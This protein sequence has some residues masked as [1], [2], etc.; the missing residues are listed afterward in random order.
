M[1]LAAERKKVGR[2][3]FQVV[4]L[5][6]D[7]CRLTY[8][9][10][11]CAA[12]IGTTGDDR[13]YNTRATCQDPNNYDRLAGK[14]FDTTADRLD[15]AAALSGVA[16]SKSGTL[17]ALV[18][19]DSDGTARNI[20]GSTSNK[21]EAQYNSSNKF[22]VKAENAAGTEILNLLSQNAILAASG[23][24][25]FMVSW[26][27]AVAGSARMF[28][29][30]QNILA[31]TGL[32]TTD[33]TIDYAGATSWT[34]GAFDSGSQP[35]DGGC[36][37]LYFAPGQ[38]T[39]W[40][41]PYLR[42]RVLSRFGNLVNLGT[43]G[44]N[45]TGTAPAIFMKGSATT[46]NT[47]NGTGGAFTAN[48][49]ADYATLTPYLTGTKQTLRFCTPLA[50]LPK[51]LGAIPALNG[52]ST[53]PAR[54]QPDR[55]I[56]ERAS[57]SATL[58][59]APH[60]DRGI[61]PYVSL[62]SYNPMTQGT[63]FTKLAARSPYYVGRTMRVLS[64]YLPDDPPTYDAANFETRSYLLDSL[65]G[66]DASGHVSITAKDALKLADDD[67]SV[68]P[69]PAKATLIAAVTSSATS[70]SIKPFGYGDL[71]Y[72]RTGYVRI[73][74]EVMRFKRDGDA[75]TVVDTDYTTAS[76]NGRG[77]F[78][79]TAAAQAADDS[80]QECYSLAADSGKNATELLYDWF[81]TYAGIDPN[82]I[83]KAGWDSEEASFMPSVFSGIVTEPV[84]VTTLVTD[85]GVPP[86]MLDHLRQIG[87]EVILVDPKE[88]KVLSA[89]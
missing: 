55:G 27:L 63:L 79:T 14:R 44:A 88:A 26:N 1:T 15:K 33:D 81:V 59:D 65:V 8:G 85:T 53:T 58:R 52:V 76:V 51:N 21:F 29:G 36:H 41:L 23:W 46:F 47:N 31:L 66:P 89:A 62:R 2:S 35:L 4:E 77:R 37:L 67:K 12:A 13:C 3:P 45:L 49:N 74:R 71:Y 73:N 56:G 57:V 80:V 20:I 7:Q 40:N 83:D 11:P 60:H 19:T 42:R 64:G 78:N 9:T 25:L 6:L 30:D 43:A 87:V 10:S 38:Y 32:T 61:D 86:H 48:T 16:G 24:H 34:I 70:F 75:F 68:A 84:G 50:G 22:R 69:F 54:L 82:I 72:S 5:E 18:R 17:I 28:D 39:D